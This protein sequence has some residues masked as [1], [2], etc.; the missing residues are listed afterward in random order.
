VSGRTDLIVEG[1]L[2]KAGVIEAT[3]VMTSC[4][5]KYQPQQGK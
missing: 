5:S 2:N 3:Q 1:R 4:P